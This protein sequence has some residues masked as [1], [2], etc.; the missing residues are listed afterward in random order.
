MGRLLNRIGFCA[1]ICCLS[2]MINFFRIFFTAE[3]WQQKT[4]RSD[5]AYYHDCY[6]MTN[7]MSTRKTLTFRTLYSFLQSVCTKPIVG[8][9]FIPN[10]CFFVNLSE[11]LDRFETSSSCILKS[12]IFAEFST[13]VT[14]NFHTGWFSSLGLYIFTWFRLYCLQFSITRFVLWLPE[15]HRVASRGDG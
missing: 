13:C 5:N 4:L 1:L 14:E 7:D 9:Q 8:K 12:N 11:I 6:V 10:C 3:N 2:K 15:S